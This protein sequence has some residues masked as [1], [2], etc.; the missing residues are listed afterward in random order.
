MPVGSELAETSFKA[1]WHYRIQY[2]TPK[3]DEKRIHRQ[4]R[5]AEPQHLRILFNLLLTINQ[6]KSI[7]PP[8][9]NMSIEPYSDLTSPP[10]TSPVNP[11]DA[12][13][14]SPPF[15]AEQP[16]SQPDKRSCPACGHTLANLDFDY[17]LT[18]R[19]ATAGIAKVY[20]KPLDKLIQMFDP[21]GKW[22]WTISTFLS[23]FQEYRTHSRIRMHW[24][25]F[26]SWVNQNMN[27]RD[28]WRER[29]DDADTREM[30]ERVYRKELD[31]LCK[32]SEFARFDIANFDTLN[33]SKLVDS[34]GN[35]SPLIETHAP[36]LSRLL[37]C[38][39]TPAAKVHKANVQDV[40]ATHITILV[41]L[42]MSAHRNSAT[43]ISTIFGLYF[44]GSGVQRRVLE[45]LH[46]LGLVPSCKVLYKHQK[47]MK[48]L[49]EKQLSLLGQDPG[50]VISWDN[51][52]FRDPIR[53]E[54]LGD[55]SKFQ[56]VTT[57]VA[58]I[59]YRFGD[60]HGLSRLHR[61]TLE[62]FDPFDLS[63]RITRFSEMQQV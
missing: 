41:I 30:I 44:L 35:L 32:Q 26:K 46:H 12:Q 33:P 42:G 60:T 13:P 37:R 24:R 11:F 54:R 40:S 23:T 22:R 6:S 2:T 59:G 17:D 15:M 10:A 34:L 5:Q 28:I 16:T 9:I 36:N 62:P 50:L 52:D 55:G 20:L 45:C 3:I 47:D 27:D 53:H 38:L 51:F 56:S 14:S 49:A 21:L 61:R 63:E 25:N 57:A 7:S 8:T 39:G 31:E 18:P 1:A 19:T 29:F 4:S 43:N 58:S 48:D